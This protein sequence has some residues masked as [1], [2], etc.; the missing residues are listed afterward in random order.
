MGDPQERP[1]CAGC[2]NEIDPDWC[3]CGEAMD[4]HTISS[5]YGPVP[6]G[7]TCGYV[8]AIAPEDIGG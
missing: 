3:H 8:T 7:C 6:L 5:N 4:A 1:K 2:D